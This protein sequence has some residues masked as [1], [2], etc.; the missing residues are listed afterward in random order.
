VRMLDEPG[1]WD[2]LRSEGTE[3]VGRYSW[4]RVAELQQALY[5][6]TARSS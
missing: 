5:E 3:S 6:R 4:E 2:R 1:L